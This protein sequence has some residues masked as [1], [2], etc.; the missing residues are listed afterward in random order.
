MK[1]QTRLALALFRTSWLRSLATVLGLAAAIGIATSVVLVIRAFNVSADEQLAGIFATHDAVVSSAA[2]APLTAAQVELLSVQSGTR[3]VIPFA[4]Y[5]SRIG[6]DPIA[7]IVLPASGADAEKGLLQ[8]LGGRV[9]AAVSGSLQVAAGLHPGDVLDVRLGHV[10]L[11]IVVTTDPSAVGSV[12]LDRANYVVVMAPAVAA[13]GHPGPAAPNGL[14]IAVDGGT[15]AL[16]GVRSAAATAGGLIVQ[17]RWQAREALLAGLRSVLQ[18]LP[19]VALIALALG[20]VLVFAVIRTST[21]TQLKSLVLLRSLGATSTRLYS[22]ALVSA[23]AHGVVGA[24]LG[25]LLSRPAAESLVASVPASTR[26]SAAPILGVPLEPLVMLGVVA[27][28]VLVVS[29]SA[30]LALRPVLMQSADDRLRGVLQPDRQGPRWPVAVLGGLLGL[31]AVLVITAQPRRFWLLAAGLLILAWLALS[32]VG[33]P[34]F[35]RLFDRAGAR[36]TAGFLSKLGSGGTSPQLRS[37]ALVMSAAVALLVSLSGAAV[38]LEQSAMPTLAG[39]GAVDLMVQDAAADDVPTQRNLGSSLGESIRATPEVTAVLPIQVGYLSV[40]GARVLVQGVAPNSRLPIVVQGTASWGALTA[41]ES[42]VSRQMKAD[43]GLDVGSVVTLPGRNGSP[44]ALRVK[45]VVDSFLWPN[46]VLVMHVSDS[47]AVWGTDGFSSFE[48]VTAN[49]AEV[50]VALQRTLAGS[51]VVLAS[52]PELATQAEKVVVDSSQLYRSLSS[53]ALLVAALLAASAVALDTVTR[54]REFGVVRAV[55]G[56]RGLLQGM[57]LVRSITLVG[58]GSLVGTGFGLVLQL[59]LAKTAASTQ[60]LPIEFHLSA[61]P[62]ASALAAS[63]GVIFVSSVGAAFR[64]RRTSVP[65]LLG[66]AD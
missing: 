37:G 28:T 36:R 25:L 57:V 8:V 41:G 20:A 14:L 54:L 2:D 49:P 43:L 18:T 1:H 63:V 40:L 3:S 56:S 30:V 31:A 65:D 52:G 17:D 7:V 60:G 5:E 19:L 48:V 33:V 51:G 11:P 23:L 16:G 59:Y 35:L 29:A 64:L 10:N 9:P 45:G 44:I 21:I 46:G 27:A 66:A 47:Q 61:I 15:E 26:N 6:A 53:V 32:L 22:L 39:M 58:A 55:G 24:V 13:A 42:F 34:M 12:A 38:D 62:P 4:R 50:R